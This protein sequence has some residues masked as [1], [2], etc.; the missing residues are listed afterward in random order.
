[1]NLIHFKDNFK[2]KSVKLHGLGD[3]SNYKLVLEY[4]E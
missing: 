4:F 1:M 2:R 3:L